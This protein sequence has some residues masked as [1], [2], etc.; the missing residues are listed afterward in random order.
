[1]VIKSNL[2]SILGNE[3]NKITKAAGAKVLEQFTRMEELAIS[4]MAKVARLEGRLHERDDLE[5][6]D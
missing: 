4:L 5:K 2:A 3:S 6:T 1:M